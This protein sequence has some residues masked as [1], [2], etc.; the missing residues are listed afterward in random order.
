[1]VISDGINARAGT[2]TSEEDRFMAWRTIDG[3]EVAPLSM[4]QLEVL[5][6]GMFQR[7]H[8]LNIIKHFVL[9]QSDGRDIIKILA[10]YHQYHAVNK[11]LE[12]TIRATME[13]G[14][15]RIG[16]IWHTQGSGKSLSMVFYAGK[17][18]ISEELE[19]PTIVVITDRNDLDDQLFGTFLKSKDLLR[20]NPIQTADRA[21]LRELLNN[22]T[23]GGIIFTTIHKFAPNVNEIKENMDPYESLGKTAEDPPYYD[24]GMV[25]TERKNVIV[26][27]D[28]AHRSQ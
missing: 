22:R 5:I 12:S 16:V 23:S 7:D 1:M 26:M 2:L 17:L 15:R 21:H 4:P 10:G 18:V 6:K 28:E 19:N 14:D 8:F 9:F 24:R 20:N 3:D 25:L 13:S 11:A 27:A